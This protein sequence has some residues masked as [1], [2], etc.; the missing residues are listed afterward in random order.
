M[1]TIHFGVMSYDVKINKN[2]RLKNGKLVFD[3]K[4]LITS[5]FYRVCGK[6]DSILKQKYKVFN[7]KTKQNKT[8][9]NKT[10]QTNKKITKKEKTFYTF[11]YYRVGGT[12][13]PCIPIVERL[14][15]PMD[16]GGY[17]AGKM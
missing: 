3:H 6:A 1:N 17:L 16:S 14:P 12:N 9:Q 8:K 4:N 10:K 15:Y 2:Y 11:F 7:Y 13:T 5:N